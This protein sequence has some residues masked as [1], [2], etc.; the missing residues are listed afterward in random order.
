MN[1]IIEQALN[2]YSKAPSSW[3]VS[4]DGRQDWILGFFNKLKF[5]DLSLEAT[6][7]SLRKFYATDMSEQSFWAIFGDKVKE[8]T[9]F[10]PLDGQK[11]QLTLAEI[12]KV[13]FKL[14]NDLGMEY[15]SAYFM[16]KRL[17][18]NYPQQAWTSD[19]FIRILGSYDPEL[20]AK[21]LAEELS[22]A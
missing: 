18:H 19:T 1:K 21:M 11:K 8:K 12:T 10:T 5:S 15:D 14:S 13:A 3:E 22:A 9:R 4:P 16:L 17:Y 20:K 7:T 2:S 6:L